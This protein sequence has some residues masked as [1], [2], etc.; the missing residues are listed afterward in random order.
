MNCCCNNNSDYGGTPYIVNAEN[1]S[2]QNMNFRTAIWTGSNLQMT[3][4]SI[5]LC[6]EIGLEMHPNTDQII[7]VEQG[8]AVV[9]MGAE[10]C[11]LSF[12]Q[13]VCKGDTIFVPAGT[14]HNVINNGR[15]LLKLTSTYAP[16]NHPKGAVHRTKA[17]AEREEY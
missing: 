6:G 3:V 8:N 17:E 16:P 13:N 4:M 1:I 2:V 14:W 10:K 9:K 11:Q 15:N 7:R 12:Q 5:P